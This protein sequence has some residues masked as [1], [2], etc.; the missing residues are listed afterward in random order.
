M[1]CHLFSSTFFCILMLDGFSK[2]RMLDLGMPV[3]YLSSDGPIYRREGRGGGLHCP[4]LT[5]KDIVITN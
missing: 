4:L 3:S 5:D 1:N 2:C